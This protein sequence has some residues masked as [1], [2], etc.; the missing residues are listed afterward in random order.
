M[1]RRLCLLDED[2]MLLRPISI[3]FWSLFILSLVCGVVLATS[4]GAWMVVRQDYLAYSST[5]SDVLKQRDGLMRVCVLKDDAAKAKLQDVKKKA[6][7]PPNIGG[8]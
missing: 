8:E 3:R 4:Y 1:T 6:P 5:L 2:R 7:V